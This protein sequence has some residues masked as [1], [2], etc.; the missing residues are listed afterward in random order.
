MA[1]SLA[2]EQVPSGYNLSKINS[3]F[4]KINAALQEALSTGGDNPNAMNADLDMNSNDL[5]NVGTINTTNLLVNNVPVTAGVT[6]GVTQVQ[7]GTNITVDNTNP[8]KPIV[9]SIASGSSVTTRTALKALSTTITKLTTLTE[10]GREG[11]FLFKSGDYSALVTADTQEGIYLKADA[12]ASTVGAWV[13]IFQGAIKAE[14][15]GCVADG[16]TDNFATLAC[17]IN[18]AS[19]G[20]L[21]LG[22]GTYLVNIPAASNFVT[23]AA[24]TRISGAGKTATII[25]FACGSYAGMS[26][27]SA[28]NGD[29]NVSRL[30]VQLSTT[31][32][33]YNVGGVTA[34]ALNSDRLTFEQVR[35]LGSNT[36]GLVIGG[37]A[38]NAD[39]VRATFTSSA[40]AG[41]PLTVSYTVGSGNTTAQM[42]TGLANAI[43]ANGT[44]SGAGIVATASGSF[45]SVVQPSTL[46]PQA[47][48]AGSVTGAATETVAFQASQVEIAYLLGGA[49]ASDVTLLDCD[50]DSTMWSFLKSNANT[51]ANRRWK[52]KG[53]R[54]ENVQAGGVSLNSPNGVFDDVLIDG[55]TIGRVSPTEIDGLPIALAHVTNFRVTGNS[56]EGTYNNNVIHI[57]DGCS[58]GVVSGNVAVFNTSKSWGAGWNGTGVLIQ[59]N[60]VSGPYRGCDTIIVVDNDLLNTSANT[61]GYGVGVITTSAVS[62]RL[63][64]DSLNLRGFST[65]INVPATNNIVGQNIHYDGSAVVI[66]GRREI[67]TAARTYYVSTAGSDSNNGLSVGAPFAT[68]NKARDA[69]LALDLNGFTVT[70]QH[71]ASQTP[72]NALTFTVAPVGGNITLDLGGSVLTTIGNAVTNSAPFNLTVQNIGIG[73]TVTG[74]ALIANVPGAQITVGS[75]VE[76]KACAQRAMRVTSGARILCIAN[77]TISGGGLAAVSASTCGSIGFFTI[78]ITLTGTPAF[79]VGFAQT[80][81]GGIVSTQGSTVTFSG[82]ATGPR[83]SFS[84][85]GILVTGGGG[86]SYFPGSSVGSGVNGTDGFYS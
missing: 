27:F 55:V 39:T 35:V 73:T 70:I 66:S 40:L 62:E 15:F 33:S 22:A 29:L 1:I 23:P 60:N 20:Q 77:F 47:I 65:P 86:T 46:S 10:A 69:A 67:L 58:Q 12:T 54:I 4:T 17:A 7:A 44:L 18:L 53:G 63:I 74:H 42:A 45:V 64:V 61:S 3:N 24:K 84:A 28:T 80:D 6:T 83:Y 21:E 49:G 59:D 30:T 76:F 13:R 26:M 85:G 68:L 19:G 9:N 72:S 2:L 43:N 51:G 50:I 71:A 56:L 78:T 38:T 79:S 11:I 32:G 75:G 5:L 31:L 48:L 34:F 25:K 8:A 52:I 82:S 81:S 57:E 37:T 41:S 36:E 16:T 14:W